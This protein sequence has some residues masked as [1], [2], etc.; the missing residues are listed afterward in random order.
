MPDSL[1]IVCPHCDQTNRVPRQRMR[2]APKCGACH[3]PLFEGRPLALSDAARF[4]KHAKYSDIPLLIDFWAAWCGPCRVMMPIFEQAASRLESHMRLVKIDSDAAPELAA[5]FSVR[6][7][8][9]LLLLRHE[10]EIAR[11]MGVMQL[12]QLV[13]WTRQHVD[14]AMV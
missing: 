5:R 1:Q 13:A 7:I 9:T 12:P 6:S 3:R 8:P 11:T 2:Q 10:R 4:A 14:E